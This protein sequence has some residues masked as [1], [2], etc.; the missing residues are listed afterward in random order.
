MIKSF[1]VFVLGMHR[2]GTS[3]ITHALQILGANLGPR[4]IAPAPDN[5]DGFFESIEVVDIND[6]LLNELGHSWDDF[7]PLPEN[8]LDSNAAARARARIVDFFERTF[9]REPL[10]AIKDP[11]LCL[12]FPLWRQVLLELGATFGSLLVVR[13]PSAIADS[14]R[15]RNGIGT[16]LSN[17]LWLTYTRGACEASAGLANVVLCLDEFNRDSRIIVDALRKLTDAYAITQIHE[18][19][20]EIQRKLDC[21][22]RTP[23]RSSLLLQENEYI[24]NQLSAGNLERR[25]LFALTE[26]VADSL[27]VR[28]LA[29]ECS[30]HLVRERA[31]ALRDIRDLS[32]AIETLRHEQAKTNAWVDNL[33]T[34]LTKANAS[35]T[36][37]RAKYDEAIRLADIS[38]A[39]YDREIDKANRANCELATRLDQALHDNKGLA[40]ALEESQREQA[41]TFAWAN[42]LA[43]D[44]DAAN[45]LNAN[46]RMKY[47]EAIRLADFSRAEY[48]CSIDKAKRS[49]SELT[50]KLEQSLHDC[51]LNFIAAR[52][53]EEREAELLRRYNKILASHSWKVTKPLRF[54]RRVGSALLQLDFTRVRDELI[55]PKARQ[56]QGESLRQRM[57]RKIMHYADSKQNTAALNLLHETRASISSRSD[58]D[59]SSESCIAFDLSLVT[60]NSLKW[61]DRYFESLVSCGYSLK[62]I[63]IHVVDNGSTDA[64]YKRLCELRTTLHDSFGAFDVVVQRNRG[65]GAGHDVNFSRCTTDFIL[66][67]NVDLEFTPGS[68]TRLLLHASADA[69]ED[70]AAWEMCQAPYEHPKHYDPVSWATNWQAYA[71]VLIRK[72]AYQQVGGFDKRIFMYCEDVELSYRFR[73]FGW[74]LKYCPDCVVI[75]HAY[76]NAG[77]LFKPLQ[78]FY[79]TLGVGYVRMRYGTARDRIAGLMLQAWLVLRREQPARNSRRVM[80]TNFVKLLRDGPHFMRGKGKTLAAYPFRGFD[81]DITRVGAD[82][83]LFPTRQSDT[84]ISIITRTYSVANRSVL[85][86]QAG[87]SICNQRYR[88][89]EWIVVQDGGDDLMPVVDEI[90][91]RRKGLKVSFIA[92]AKLGRSHAGNAGLSAASGE[93]CM[94]LDDDDLLYADHCDVLVN[95]L[96]SNNNISAAY[97]LA[98]EVP[99]DFSDGRL[100]EGDYVSHSGHAQEWDY[101]VLQRYNFIP[102]QAIMFRRKLF[103]ER[104]GFDVALDQLEDWNLWLRYGY[105][106]TFEFV[107]KTTSLYRVPLSEEKKSARQ[108]LLHAAYETAKASADDAIRSLNETRTC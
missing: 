101:S 27:D 100:I 77:N 23:M 74:Q 12:T 15:R 22:R 84:L 55:R 50:S 59:S 73:S 45:T 32:S 47:D 2:S 13:D 107:R 87:I 70:F 90:A 99:T 48:D 43:A 91:S 11:R 10:W 61:L 29:S 66:V 30:A 54:A 94:F 72:A 16:N 69:N 44:L 40:N 39:E 24:R 78:F 14:L 58:L 95:R 65:F 102:I 31:H 56:S 57:F 68:L 75:H 98:F 38:R 41:K 67:S 52:T 106:S 105:Q 37:W 20:F 97:A 88:N 96:I 46:L 1:G 42:S 26:I 35:S 19:D 17:A 8:W 81:F 18:S 6:G 49:I 82:L 92:N 25:S 60:Y 34:D 86:R 83:A 63:H 89:I 36:N 71:C 7:R 5:P 108:H 9:A 4:L 103:L 51:A 104:G 3:T 76:E 79:G 64:T 33:V 93:F 80:A 28:A 85:L 21:L 62:K 53:L